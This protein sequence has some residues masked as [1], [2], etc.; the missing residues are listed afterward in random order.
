MTINGDSRSTFHLEPPQPSLLAMLAAGFSPVYPCHV[1][2]REMRTKP[3]GT[4]P[5]KFAEFKQNE[6]IKLV[7]NPDYW[8]K[9]QPYLDAIDFT[10]IPNRSTAMLGLL[11]GKFDMTFSADSPLAVLKDVK[12]QRRGASARC[13]RPIRQTNLLVNRD[14]PPFDDAAHPPAM[15]LALDRKAFIDILSQG[16]TTRRRHAAA[17]RRRLGHAAGVA[18]DRARLRRRRREEPRR[19][20]QDHEEARATARTSRSRSRYRPATSPIYRDPAVILIDQL[21]QIYIEGELEPIDTAVW[22]ARMPRKD[23]TVGMNVQGV[24]I[25]DPDVVFYETFSCGSERNY[26]GYC[27]PELEKLFDEAVALTDLEKRKE[28]VWEID[29][30][31]QEDGARPVIYHGQAAT[32]WHPRSRA[33]TCREQIYNHWRFED[34]WLDR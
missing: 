34:V 27:N 8:K 30:K 1:T 26:T 28:L 10:I 22:Y 32:C 31:L 25:D 3:I 7:K 13:C 5:F 21:K 29:K 17:A 11:A 4:G 12:A 6:S 18:G 19:R 9:G 2:G 23:Y 14:K 16:T 24:G 15:A 20:P 33:S